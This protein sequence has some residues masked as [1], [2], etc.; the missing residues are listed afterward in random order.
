MQQAAIVVAEWVDVQHNEILFHPNVQGIIAEKGGATSHGVVV[1]RERNIPIIVNV[2]E[3]KRIAPN[4][5]LQMDAASGIIHVNGGDAGFQAGE[6]IQAEEPIYAFVWSKGR[7]ALAPIEAGSEGAVAIHAELAMQGMQ[8][9]WFDMNDTGMGVV[10]E[11]GKVQLFQR[12]SDQDR[13]VEWL[14]ETHPVTS[15]E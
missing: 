12:P 15:V 2:P 6:A 7:G 11:N 10:Y 4:D 14:N 3:A 9:G 1:A 8:E 13:M 5:I